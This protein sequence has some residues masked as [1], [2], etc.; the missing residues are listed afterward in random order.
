[1]KKTF[2]VIFLVLLLGM[3]SPAS[4]QIRIGV[5]AGKN[6]SNMKWDWLDRLL[7]AN[8]SD[9]TT[10][11][12]SCFGAVI[13][14]GLNSEFG[15]KFEPMYVAKGTNFKGYGGVNQFWAKSTYIEVPCM[16]QLFLAKSFVQPYLITGPC[17]GFKL[18]AETNDSD[19]GFG[20]KTIKNIETSLTLGIGANFRLHQYFLVFFEGRYTSGLST[21]PK[22]G[23][24]N[25]KNRGTQ[26]LAGFTF[27]VKD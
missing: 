22:E 24:A 3:I 18:N 7:E 26:L 6:F 15:L 1:M 16:F 11:T 14:I 10:R 2:F 20:S 13:E 9:L 4:T 12:S 25:I 19:I 21:L 27:Q 23:K 17:V 5:L 8:G